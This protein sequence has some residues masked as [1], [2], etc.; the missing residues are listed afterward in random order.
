[1]KEGEMD[2]DECQDDKDVGHGML[3]TRDNDG[4]ESCRC[5]GKRMHTRDNDEGKHEVFE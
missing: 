2:E 4:G 3:T 5:R 1:M